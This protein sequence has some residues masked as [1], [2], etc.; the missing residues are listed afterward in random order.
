MD[1]TKTCMHRALNNL[2]GSVVSSASTLLSEHSNKHKDNVQKSKHEEESEFHSKSLHPDYEKKRKKIKILLGSLIMVI[3]MIA[4]LLQTTMTIKIATSNH[5]D[6]IS[7][8]D[9]N[10][11]DVGISKETF[12]E[13]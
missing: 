5:Y 11:N 8:S 7:S 10:D 6:H 1:K 2:L 9:G 3:T 4:L 13:N 12:L